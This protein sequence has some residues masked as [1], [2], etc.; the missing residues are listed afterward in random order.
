VALEINSRPERLDPPRRILRMAVEAGI[1][2]A[3]D[4][5]AHAPGQLSWQPFGV[6]RAVECG[7]DPDR[8]VTTWDVDRL[9]AWSRG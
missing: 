2:L 4:T 9:L 6:A 5:D 3:L 1:L 8:I 7:A